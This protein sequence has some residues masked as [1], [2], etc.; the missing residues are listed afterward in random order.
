MTKSLFFNTDRGFIRLLRISWRT[1]RPYGAAFAR[2]TSGANRSAREVGTVASMEHRVHASSRLR[3]TN[4]W[5]H[6]SSLFS[7]PPESRRNP[8]S[9]DFASRNE[10]SVWKIHFSP[11]F[12][13]PLHL[14]LPT[15]SAHSPGR[16]GSSWLGRFIPPHSLSLLALQPFPWL[17][18]TLGAKAEGYLICRTP[19]LNEKSHL[20]FRDGCP[21][22]KHGG[23]HLTGEPR[24]CNNSV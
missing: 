3:P 18:E 10:T 8:A 7:P 23:L 4:P 1:A 9:A 19:I 5:P 16:V 15:C 20:S 21:Q 6:H 2:T 24:R 11:A 14:D 22:S 17:G 13:A 12:A